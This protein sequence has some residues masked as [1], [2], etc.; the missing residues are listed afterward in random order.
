MELDI[1]KLMGDDDYMHKVFLHT[2]NYCYAFLDG[3]EDFPPDP[4]TSIAAQRFWCI[5]NTTSP[6]WFHMW[7]E[8][9]Y[10]LREQIIDIKK[11]YESGN[12]PSV[13][14]NEERM[15]IELVGHIET[16]LETNS[17]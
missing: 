6:M 15:F 3:H 5:L 2:M 13:G 16:W 10:G 7:P 8:K 14:T 4:N 11:T 17:R 12:N 9:H 1:G